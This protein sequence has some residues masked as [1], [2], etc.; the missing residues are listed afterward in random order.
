MYF[1]R[2]NSVNL[3]GSEQGKKETFFYIFRLDNLTNSRREIGTKKK[4][5]KK[6]LNA[7]CKGVFLVI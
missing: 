5:K 7:F 2:E 6:T 1:V 3:R 4:R